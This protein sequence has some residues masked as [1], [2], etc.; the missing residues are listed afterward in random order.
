MVWS[1]YTKVL[2][3]CPENFA[4]QEVREETLRKS[5]IT[6]NSSTENSNT[7]ITS[8]EGPSTTTSGGVPI[9]PT[10]KATDSEKVEEKVE[11][12]EVEETA[13][14]TRDAV[15]EVPAETTP[16]GGGTEKQNGRMESGTLEPS[17]THAQ[18]IDSN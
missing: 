2:L 6:A 13:G 4:G 11:G 8:G 9:Q 1:V 15:E 10:S 12:K 17:L 18:N 5:G 7:A 14:G 16:E 3:D